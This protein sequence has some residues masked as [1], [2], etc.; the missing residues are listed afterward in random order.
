LKDADVELE[1]NAVD[2]L[3][4]YYCR[5]SGVRNLKKHVEKIFRKAALKIVQDLGEEGLPEPGAKPAKA[6]A[7]A[8]S[9]AD[10]RLVEAVQDNE[11][12]SASDA[13]QA[14]EDEAARKARVAGAAATPALKADANERVKEA[15]QDD[16]PA[17][18]SED[19]QASEDEAARAARVAGAVTDP[20]APQ[21]SFDPA[22][23]DQQGAASV[24]EGSTVEST[25]PP[26]NAPGA[27]AEDPEKEVTTVERAPMKVPESVHVRIT[28][29][30]L[31]DY[32]GPPVYQKDRMYA[33]QPPPGVS[34]GLGYLG[35]GSGAVMPI[36]AI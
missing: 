18:A 19:A 36:E 14:G 17:S 25:E 12:A 7:R 31:K 16:E 5:E 15:V 28:A 1:E 13:A 21:S 2:R 24:D 33:R 3:I 6:D 9:A 4:K 35:N 8:S 30:N 29:D 34:T 22:A 20:A 10:E 11:P 32:V 27:A 26:S 23:K